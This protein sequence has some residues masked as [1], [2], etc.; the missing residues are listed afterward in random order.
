MLV[1]VFKGQLHVY[2]HMQGDYGITILAQIS[3]I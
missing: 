2:L 3:V 1:I